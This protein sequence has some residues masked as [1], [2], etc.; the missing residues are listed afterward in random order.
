MRA[1]MLFGG[2]SWWTASFALAQDPPPR[3][4]GVVL[5][6]VDGAPL[7]GALVLLEGHSHVFTA[8]DGRY[9][10]DSGPPPGEYVLAAVTRDCRIAASRLS[11]L[12]ASPLRLDLSVGLQRL[13]GAEAEL[14]RRQAVGTGVKVATREEILRLGERDL[15]AVLR[16]L[17]PSM[18]ASA[19][20]R[21]GA[22]IQLRERG[23]ST[24]TGSRTPLILIDDVRVTDTRIL[25]SFDVDEIARIEIAPG[26]AGGWAFGS[27]GANG[28]IH[29]RTQDGD[30]AR[31][32]Y[33]GAASRIR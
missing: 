31:N 9:A 20:S 26:A 19:A 33:C 13:E 10:F 7:G 6:S 24:V 3:L 28:V 29:I 25:E 16:R 15:P 2:L 11:L 32:P 8:S 30:L 17:A 12:D 23:I 4:Q 27:E 1:A 14:T 5:D 22:A 18:V 21:P